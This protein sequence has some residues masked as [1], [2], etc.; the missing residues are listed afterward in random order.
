MIENNCFDSFSF[1][2]IYI[3]VL[4]ILQNLTSDFVLKIW[5]V[6]HFKMSL[7]WFM[8]TPVNIFWMFSSEHTNSWI[9]FKWVDIALCNF[10][11]FV[12]ISYFVEK[13]LWKNQSIVLSFFFLY[14][15]VFILCYFW[16]NL[17]FRKLYFIASIILVVFKFP[18]NNCYC[19]FSLDKLFFSRYKN[20]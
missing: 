12:F 4:F 3:F 10:V 13:W 9:I 20:L 16:R 5:V 17:I 14:H 18:I 11:Y 2:L 19:R 1:L 8:R 15:F 7:I 6:Q